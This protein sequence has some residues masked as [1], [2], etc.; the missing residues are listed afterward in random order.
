MSTLYYVNY[1]GVTTLRK[2]GALISTTYTYRF[3][4]QC[5]ATLYCIIDALNKYKVL[6]LNWDGKYV[7]METHCELQ[8]YYK[9]KLVLT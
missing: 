7:L 6:T 1:Y 3:M 9:C 5:N 2:L 8:F 4:W